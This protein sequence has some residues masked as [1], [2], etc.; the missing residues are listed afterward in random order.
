ML[1]LLKAVKTFMPR[2]DWSYYLFGM[3]L[4]TSAL[5][6][7]WRLSAR[8]LPQ[9]KRVVGIALLTLIPFYNFLALKFNAN[10]VLTPLWAA[11]TWWF[12]RSYETRK[13][14][15]AFLA[16]AGAAGAILGKY[17]SII[18]VAAFGIAILADH[19]RDQYV[20]SK[21]FFL[22][23]VTA[24]AL[25]TPHID[26]LITHQFVTFF[27]AADSHSTTFSSAV[28]AAVFFIF[29]SFGYIIV[30]FVL[31]FAT[32]KP[33]AAAIM[34]MLWPKDAN[35]R[36]LIV[37][38]VAPFILAVTIVCLKVALSPV[39]AIST[40]TLLPIVLL[41]SPLMHISRRGAADILLIAI[42]FPLFM[43][44][45]SPIVAVMIQNTGIKDYRD[46]YKLISEALLKTWQEQTSLPLKIIGGTDSIVN[47]AAFYMA[48]PPE[49]LQIYSP[50]A[51][52]WVDDEDIRRDGIAMICPALMPVCLS[53][54]DH[55]AQH[56][57][58][59]SPREVTLTRWY[60]NI[61]GDPVRYQII[62]IP[63]NPDLG[64]D[65]MK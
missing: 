47:G 41:S 7:S 31:G 8:Y 38:F 32:I 62:I 59:T 18:L 33:G 5:W 27:Y 21:A 42:A 29:G 53:L 58:G 11:A 46:Q 39:W 64:N 12:I 61:A 10:S 26:W 50:A 49:T 22:T 20:D 40:M 25:L 28:I 15:W 17:W 3:T 52:P 6:I 51:T 9:D 55:F 43:L 23:L 63:P 36:F 65:F 34:D 45:S 2:A 16:G 19:R 4:A 54:M 35:R 13:L 14:G 60:F 48:Q 44:A 56:F 37:L 24:T 1:S 30:P 57:G